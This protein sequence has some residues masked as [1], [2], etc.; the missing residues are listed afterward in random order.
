M[1]APEAG[2]RIK[3]ADDIAGSGGIV[4]KSAGVTVLS[5]ANSFS[6]GVE[7]MSGTL[8]LHSPMAG[9]SGT[10][11]FIGGLTAYGH[12][13]IDAAALSGTATQ[14]NLATSLGEFTLG[15]TIDLPDLAFDATSARK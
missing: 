11:R 12:L 15:D 13:V 10:I 5:G 6:G 9:G 7:L 3:I 4:V 2:Q 14:M 8:E 1:F